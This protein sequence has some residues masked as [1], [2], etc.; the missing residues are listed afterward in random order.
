MVIYGDLWIG[1]PSAVDNFFQL[2][3]FVTLVQRWE[4]WPGN[5][6]DRLRHQNTVPEVPNSSYGGCDDRTSSAG[7]LVL[8]EESDLPSFVH[9]SLLL[10]NIQHLPTSNWAENDHPVTHPVCSISLCTISAQEPLIIVQVLP[11]PE[12]ATIWPMTATDMKKVSA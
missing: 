10:P 9:D 11:K 7:R 1:K 4:H 8:Q 6:R 5:A 3:N 2:L 12:M